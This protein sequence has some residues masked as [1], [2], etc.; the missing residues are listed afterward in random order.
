MQ[1]CKPF[2]ILLGACAMLSLGCSS[3][4]KSGTSETLFRGQDSYAGI[5][6]MHPSNNRDWNPDVAVL[7]YAEIGKDSVTVHNIR[8]CT[9]QADNEYV[10]K[11]YDRT[12][13]L[14]KIR[15]V[16]FIVAPFKEAQG[17]AH[18]MMSFGFE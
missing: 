10:V 8:N 3:V 9:Y 4:P 13:D 11:H 12:F 15:S 1:H 2:T 5:S 18:T 6:L 7:P 17:L 14:D 16:D